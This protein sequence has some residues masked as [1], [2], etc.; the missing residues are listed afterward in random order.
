MQTINIS[1]IKHIADYEIERPTLRPAMIALKD[2]RR[3]RVGDHLTFLFENRETVCYQIQ[4]MMRIER[5]VKPGEIAHEV[6]T[7]NELIP[8]RGE[9]SA[10]LLIEY[11]TPEERDI[12][13]KRLL[14]L[15]RHIGLEA[16]GE[17]TLAIFDD[18]Q[19]GDTRISSVQYLKFRLTPAQ[20]AAWSQGARIVVD[21]PHYRA[22]RPL[23]A[24]ELA[25][26]A[27]DFA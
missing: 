23:S 20:M 5:L 4:E 8:A 24:A 1:E 21:H 25:E 17:R 9:L 22:E 27:R 11:E 19:I 7:Y 18:R 14:G 3:V 15:E 2:R 16:G 13:L 26:L 10:S 12:E 6:E